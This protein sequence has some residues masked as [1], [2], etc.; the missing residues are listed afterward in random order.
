MLTSDC[1]HTGSMTNDRLF[2]IH[3]FSFIFS[4]S[5]SRMHEALPFNIENHHV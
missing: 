2:L 4:R 5:A 3:T 1:L